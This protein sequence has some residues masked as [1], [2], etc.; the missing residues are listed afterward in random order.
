M[1][2]IGLTGGFCSGKTFVLKV[3][4]EQGCYTMRAD[5]LAKNII[6][7]K[8][9]P[10]LQEIISAFGPEIY[11]RE[12]GLDKEK[13]SEILFEDHEKRN[14]INTIV[15]P[16]V[17]EER[18]NK[19]RAIAETRIYDF[20]I[21]ESALLLES[22]IYN[23][24]EKIIVVYTSVAEQLQRAMG[25]DKLTRPEAE[26]R[27]QSQFPLKEKLKVANYTI[28]SSGPFAK[29]R[30]NTMEVFHLLKKDFNYL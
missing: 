23:E 18:R 15:H 11:D 10:I 13:F 16:L 17:S 14:F 8:D 29:T 28:D 22:G 5:E 4:E 25:R 24:F 9:S 19:I 3:L 20:L 21:Y 2:A 7:S 27:I 1:H 26:K 12:K 6:F 30:A